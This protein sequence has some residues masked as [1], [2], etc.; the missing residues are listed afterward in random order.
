MKSWVLQT[1]GENPTVWRLYPGT[2]KTVGR[3]GHADFIIDAT[4]V[5]RVH[6]RL[7]AD[8]SDQLVVD[9]LASTNGTSVNGQTVVRA[10][11]KAGDTLTIG[12]VDFTV[13]RE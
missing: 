8:A 3:S 4:L 5:S 9:D 2:A 13:S 11:L 7:T 12:R 1:T 6:C 10:V